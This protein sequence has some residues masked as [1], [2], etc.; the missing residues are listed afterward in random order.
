MKTSE[1]DYDFDPTLVATAPASPRDAARLMVVDR[2]RGSIAHRT[3]RDLPA[4]LCAGDHLLVNET[5]VLR[6]RLSLHRAADGEIGAFHTEGLLLEPSA[7]RRADGVADMWRLLVRHAKRFHAGERLSLHDAHGIDHGDQVE[8][9]RRDA[10]AW[11]GRFHAGAGG[12]DIAAILE[13]SGLTPLPPYILKARKDRHEEVD[14]DADRAE[15]ETVYARASERG[16]V[17]APTAGLHFTDGLLAELASRGIGRS[18]VTLHVGAGTFKPVE[19]EDLADHAMHREHYAVSADTI[20]QLRA[21]APRRQ[22]GNARIVAVGTTTVRALES[23]PANALDRGGAIAAS[24]GIL[25]S[26]GFHFR[27]TDAL[28][29]NFHLPRS[30]LLALV[31][32]FCGMELMREAYA[33]AV[34]ERYRF[35]SYGDAMLIV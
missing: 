13:R 14:D 4:I 20:T 28:L 10:E 23:L 1:L 19:A 7:E 32:A 30:T 31:G 3:V 6:A 25:I 16:S 9:V 18:A 15:Y 26:P 17:A 21:L 2:A 29:T 33:T 12:G 22:S 5:S 8:L 24:T 27:F 35:Y 11:I 34:R